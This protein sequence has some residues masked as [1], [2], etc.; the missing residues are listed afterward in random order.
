MSVMATTVTPSAT[1]THPMT[2]R[3]PSLAAF[4]KY[5]PSTPEIARRNAA[6]HLD[7]RQECSRHLVT[8]GL[9]GGMHEPL[10]L[11]YREPGEKATPLLRPKSIARSLLRL[12][13]R[14]AERCIISFVRLYEGG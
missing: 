4:P 7:G 8:R 10:I 12:Q 6:E 13:V 14:R 5:D 1:T 2:C 11:T 3:P 9:E